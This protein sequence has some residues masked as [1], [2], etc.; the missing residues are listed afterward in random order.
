MVL[1]LGALGSLFMVFWPWLL[2]VLNPLAMTLVK[3]L[4]PNQTGRVKFLTAL[5][6]CLVGA[7]VMQRDKLGVIDWNDVGLVLLT[8][9]AFLAQSEFVY[10]TYYKGSAFE[11]WLNALLAKVV[12][13]PPVT[14]T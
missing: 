14:V 10:R 4:K 1:D 5:V 13:P 7:A 9:S 12:T 11:Q 8:G 2:G 3:N 6:F